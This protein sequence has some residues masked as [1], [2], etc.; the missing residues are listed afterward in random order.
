MDML[1]DVESVGSWANQRLDVIEAAR[2]ARWRRSAVTIGS[3]GTAGVV[4]NALIGR[5]A[6]MWFRQLVRP[7][8]MPTLAVFTV[9]GVAYY[10]AMAVVLQRAQRRR[11]GRSVALALVVIAGNELWNVAF[12]R[13]RSTRAGFAGLSVFVVPVLA[14]R[15]SVDADPT[16]RRLTDGYLLWLAYDLWWTHRLWQLNPETPVV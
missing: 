8:G 14:L 2:R 3:V 16:S 6:L 4:G 9:V 7:R 10:A 1:G 15:R 5:D 12:F 13:R 11:D